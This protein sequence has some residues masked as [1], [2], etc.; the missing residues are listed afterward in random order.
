MHAALGSIESACES[1]ARG[2]VHFAGARGAE[3]LPGF[4]AASDLYVWPAVHE[5][6]GM[7]MLES[8]AAGVPVVA[9]RVRGVPDVVEDGIGGL[10]APEGDAAALADLVNRLLR[11]DHL[12]HQLGLQGQKRI[13][14]ERTVEQAARIRSQTVDRA[15]VRRDQRDNHRVEP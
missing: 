6:Y 5:A 4:Y 12:R 2:R 15:L 14:S 9:G 10:L 11:D 8:Q 3:A 13:T 7:A 1:T